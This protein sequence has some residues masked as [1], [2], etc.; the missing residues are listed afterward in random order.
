MKAKAIN[1]D[2][3]SGRRAIET[4]MPSNA[5]HTERV[6]TEGLARFDQKTEIRQKTAKRAFEFSPSDGSLFKSPAQVR[7]PLMKGSKPFL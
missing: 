5:L 7:S 6:K 2:F 3:N 1:R 4:K